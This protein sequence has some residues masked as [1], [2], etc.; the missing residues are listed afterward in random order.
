M[1]YV[2]RVIPPWLPSHPARSVK[3]STTPRSARIRAARPSFSTL[4]AGL[5][6]R[7]DRE[8]RPQPL[9]SARAVLSLPLVAA[10]HD[11]AGAA[12]HSA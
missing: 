7:A 2:T 8:L 11:R 6:P 3:L 9:P 4:V 5:P 10:F 1:G 12:L